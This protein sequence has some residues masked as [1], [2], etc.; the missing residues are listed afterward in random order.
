[1]EL[2]ID[3]VYIVTGGAGALADAVA[4]TFGAAGARLVLVD[5]VAEALRERAARH[6]AV[7]HTAD[8]TDAAAAVAMV[9]DIEGTLGRVDGVIHTA[10]AFAMERAE[11][12][13]SALY[14][15]MFDVNVRTLVNVTRAALPGM[16]ARRE[17]FIAGISSHVV[18]EGTGAASMTLY[19]AAKAAVA[20][21]LR[22][23]EREVRPS[24]VRVA[25]VYPLAAI[26]TPGN[27]REMP[28]ADPRSWVNPAAIA[29]T[30]LFA[31]TRGPRG[32]LTELPIGV[33]PPPIKA[34]DRR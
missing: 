19:A 14:D 29:E 3:G 16:L 31:A 4:T 9:A 2:R 34:G 6:G 28:D 30:L 22:S 11:L 26:D 27:R 7:P 8:L 32:R 12:S 33:A 25:V 23:L 21:Y 5:R 17:G 24:G 18:W 1:M 13:D 15:R 10:G 20:F